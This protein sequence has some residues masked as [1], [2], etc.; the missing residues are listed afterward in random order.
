MERIILAGLLLVALA[1]AGARGQA[2]PPPERL[3]EPLGLAAF[4]AEVA[5]PDFTLPDL[6]GREVSLSDHRGRVV[7][8]AFWTTW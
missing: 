3:L 6:E 2:L 5:A 8:L 4:K 1:P 7:F